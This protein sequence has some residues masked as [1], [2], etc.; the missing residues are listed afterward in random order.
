MHNIFFFFSPLSVIFFELC[1]RIEGDADAILFFFFFFLVS[2]GGRFLLPRYDRSMGC[3]SHGW[4]GKSIISRHFSFSLQSRVRR[5]IIS[6][7]GF[8][9]A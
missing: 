8:G 1:L 5:L 6:I 3:Y 4:M 7:H 9:L 2:N